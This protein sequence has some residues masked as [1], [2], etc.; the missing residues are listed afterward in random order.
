MFYHQNRIASEAKVKGEQILKSHTLILE[1]AFSPHVS[2]DE[3]MICQQLIPNLNSQILLSIR[4]DN[5]QI[6][7]LSEALSLGSINQLISLW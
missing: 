6:I 4:Q 7:H 3:R 1:Q 2:S 5:E